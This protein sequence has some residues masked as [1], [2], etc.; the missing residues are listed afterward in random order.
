M[1]EVI[2]QGRVT[3]TIERNHQAV[4]LPPARLV[5][6]YRLTAGGGEV[7]TVE[8]RF[9]DSMGVE[10]WQEC[11][12]DTVCMLVFA[13]GLQVLLRQR[14]AREAIQPL[15]PAPP[16]HAPVFPSDEHGPLF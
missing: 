2:W 9:I 8:A 14:P 3:L 11:F 4:E 6:D 12:N 13:H 16:A 15:P 5:P 7:F 10:S 1:S